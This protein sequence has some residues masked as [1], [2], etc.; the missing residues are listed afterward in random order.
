MAATQSA[1]AVIGVDIGK[2]SFHIIGLDGRGVIVLRQKWSRGQ[3]ARLARIQTACTGGVH[4]G[5][6]RG[7][8]RYIERLRR[9]RWRNGQP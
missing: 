8:L 4:T 6:P 1:I 3:A 5:P 2:N 7:R 9:P